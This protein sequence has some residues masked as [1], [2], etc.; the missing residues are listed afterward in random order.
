MV[1]LVLD[2]GTSPLSWPGRSYDFLEI[3]SACL[4]WGGE[5]S[6][7]KETAVVINISFEVILQ[8]DLITPEDKLT[9]C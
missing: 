9:S 2:H 3:H 7:L 5:C 1:L 8:L 6:V 4:L